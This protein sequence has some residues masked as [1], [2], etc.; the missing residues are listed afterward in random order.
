MSR[1]RPVV[2]QPWWRRSAPTTDPTS[3][4]RLVLHVLVMAVL[5]AAILAV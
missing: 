5:L 4:A 1:S 3:R 2:G